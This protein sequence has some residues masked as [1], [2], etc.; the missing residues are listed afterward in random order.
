MNDIE[1]KI[2]TQTD[3]ESERATGLMDETEILRDVLDELRPD[4]VF[5][6]IGA[7]IGLY[8]LFA[9]R[10]TNRV[11]TFEPHPKNLNTLKA[12]LNRNDVSVEVVRGALLDRDGEAE[13][14]VAADEAGAGTHTFAHDQVPDTTITVPYHEGDKLV[15]SGEIPAP[16]V[17]KLDI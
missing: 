10:Q 8:S 17:A 12:N 1:I 16:T 2:R 9:A 13:L 3:L 15:V 7:N 4:D 5:Y 14:Y 6:D 11:I